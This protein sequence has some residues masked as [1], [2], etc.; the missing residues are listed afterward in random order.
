MLT[1]LCPQRSVT[2]FDSEK[3]SQHSQQLD[4]GPPSSTTQRRIADAVS[5][6]QSKAAEAK[7]AAQKLKKPKVRTNGSRGMKEP[8]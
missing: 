4:D 6:A 1:A 7:K 8:S 3:F 5:E 2:P